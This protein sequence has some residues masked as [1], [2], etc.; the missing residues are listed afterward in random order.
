ML[1]AWVGALEASTAAWAGKTLSLTLYMQVGITVMGRLQRT[2]FSFLTAFSGFH[3]KYHVVR[4][5]LT[6]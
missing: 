4:L 6:L 1:L 2:C 5:H 3:S